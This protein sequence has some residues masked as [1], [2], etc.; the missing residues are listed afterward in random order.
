MLDWFTDT[1]GFLQAS[2]LLQA[3]LA[4][5]CTFVL[6]DP[7]TVGSGLLV[8]EGLMDYAAAFWGLFAGIVLGDLGLYMVG[9]FGGDRAEQWQ[10]LDR[11]RFVT[12]EALFSRNLFKAVVIS[13]F[14]P[15]MRLPFY[16]A[17]GV[18]RTPF[19]K[20]FWL[21]LVSTLAWIG[22][23]LPLVVEFGGTV[24]DQAGK[25]GLLLGPGIVLLVV[26]LEY[27]LKR[28]RS[29]S[30]RSPVASGF[31][32]WPPWIFYPPVLL[33]CMWLW[34]RWRGIALPTV[35]N[36]MIYA[37]G[38]LMESKSDILAMVPPH[39]SHLVAHWTVVTAGCNALEAALD[40][41]EQAGFRFPVVGKPDVGQRG[42][43]VRLL[44]EHHELRNYLQSWKPGTRLLLQR[45]VDYP[46]EVGL[47][48]IR[49][50][51]E[52]RGFIFSIT[53]K[54]FPFVQGDG[55]STLAQLIETH[56]RGRLLQK[57][58]KGRFHNRLGDVLKNGERQPLVFAGN[59]A[60]GAVFRDG[61]RLWTLQLE[62]AVHDFAASLPEFW[63]GR[64][65]A[66]FQSEEELM[67][68]KGFMVVEINAAGS[69]ATHIWDPEMGLGQAYTALFRQYNYL[70]AI[71]YANRLRGYQ[72]LPLLTIL[73]DIRRHLAMAPPPGS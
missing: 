30:N 26:L 7:A 70:Y 65:D 1:V 50:P 17:A 24:M 16:V 35:A 44:Q 60:Q 38:F 58:Y 55:V 31:E 45:Y 15:G 36:P 43:G 22:L 73:M 51:E 56:P 54:E 13:R 32:F 11:T 18:L 8:A 66:R 33:Y 63:F 5:L 67:Q 62:Q 28:K 49:H 3:L 19:W 39:T 9:R 46:R 34:L 59:H 48:Y 41:M 40:A 53:D 52:Q 12:A 47:F 57:L 27:R 21:V 4:A 69:E 2:P 25:L 20:F 61:M 68:G 10:W 72:P 71:G 6:E 29:P 64:L 37:G 14:M 42:V 23:L